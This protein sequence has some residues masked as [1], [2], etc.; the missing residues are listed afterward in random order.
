[1]IPELWRI[2]HRREEFPGTVTLSLTQVAGTP[3][4]IQPG[5][6]NMLYAF[7]AGEA[8]ISL[9]GPSASSAEPLTHTIKGQGLATQAL[10]K[11]EVGAQLGIRG[12]FGQ[13]WP[14]HL[15][16]NRPLVI[17]T[18]GLGLAPL[19]P[20]IYSFLNGHLPARSLQVFYGA[21]RPEEMLYQPEL[22]HWRSSFELVTSVDHAST[23]WNGH[24]GVITDPL[25]VTHLECNDAL[26]FVCGPEI[27]MRFCIQVLL[28]KGVTESNIYL[29]MERNMKCAIGIC[30]HCQWGPNFVCKDGP[31]FCYR[32]IRSWFQI[33]SL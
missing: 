15:A 18:G 1:M 22:G 12:P 23:D 26:V 3:S 13:G 14:T 10:C 32:D 2:T 6:F 11:L 28:H 33:N 4:P 24:I 25:R 17:I 9:S 7:G 19:R 30:G 16:E 8:A 5:Q 31:V 27:M 20:L 29:S 21:R